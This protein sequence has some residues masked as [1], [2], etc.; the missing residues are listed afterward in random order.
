MKQ[1][2]PNNIIFAALLF[3]LFL[4]GCTPK[5]SPFGWLA[6]TWEINR[7]AGG[8]RLEIWTLKK[9]GSFS[10]KGIRVEAKD[11]SLLEKIDLVMREDQYYYIATVPEQNNGNPIEF[12]M[13]KSEG[14]V[15]TFENPKHDFPQ[16]IIYQF[17]PVG[18]QPSHTAMKGDSLLVRIETMD[19][20]GVD[21]G[22]ERK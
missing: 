3:C 21:Y 15:F 18:G 5:K 11:T 16:R 10:A 9:D 6:G 7:T 19:G 2:T 4:S 14:S 22:F 17:K 13:T 1:I 8:N 12:K 20:N